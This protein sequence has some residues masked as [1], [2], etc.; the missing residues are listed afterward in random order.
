MNFINSIILVVGIGLLIYDAILASKHKTTISQK[1]QELFPTIVDWFIGV[2]GWIGLCFLKRYY[3]ELDF[4]LSIFI[5]GFWGHIW[6]PN[7]ER[8]KKGIK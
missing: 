1:C 2:G 7:E 6:I 4:N 5:A 3:P 8:Y